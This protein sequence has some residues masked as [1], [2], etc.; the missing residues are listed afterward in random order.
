DAHAW[1]DQGEVVE[2][3][4][5]PAQE[6][7]ALVIAL[8]F[9]LDV[10]GV[11]VA[12]TESVDLDRVVDDEVD[13]DQ[14]VDLARV[15]ARALHRRPHRGKVHDSRH[16]CEVLHQHARGEEGQLGILRRSFR[17]RG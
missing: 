2:R 4:L 15:I 11:S 17:P 9:P 13:W 1:R 3:L 10:A 5:G 16:S 14:W 12:E 6:G 7:I 8:Y